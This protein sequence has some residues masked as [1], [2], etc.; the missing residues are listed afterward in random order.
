MATIVIDEIPN[1]DCNGDHYV[2][3]YFADKKEILE[4]RHGHKC[5]VTGNSLTIEY[6]DTQK[7]CDTRIAEL[8]LSYPVE[9][10]E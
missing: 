3:S 1:C 5:R 4:V 9:E 8:G 2:L 7:Q 10:E 6:F